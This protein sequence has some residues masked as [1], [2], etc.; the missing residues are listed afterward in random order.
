MIFNWIDLDLSTYKYHLTDPSG[1]NFC[2]KLFEE[3]MSVWRVGVPI[4]RLE[5]QSINEAKEKKS[6]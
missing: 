1:F 5:G 3:K 2:N 4:G 6:H